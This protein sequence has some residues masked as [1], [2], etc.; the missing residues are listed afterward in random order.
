MFVFQ[1]VGLEV[2]DGVEDLFSQTVVNNRRDC[3]L[4]HVVAILMEDE[5]PNNQVNSSPK[6][7][8]N[9]LVFGSKANLN[10]IARELKLAQT[11]KVDGDLLEDEVVAPL[12][13]QFEHILDQIVPEFVLDE[14][15]NICDNLIRN[16]HFLLP[17]AFFE[18]SLH[19]A[20]PVFVSANLDAVVHACFNDEIRVQGFG[21]IVRCMIIFVGQ[22]RG[23]EFHQNAL[24]HMVAVDVIDQPD[25]IWLQHSDHHLEGL[26]PLCELFNDG[27]HDSGA[28]DIAR[29][30]CG[31]IANLF[32]KHL[33]F[34]WARSLDDF[35]TEVVSELVYHGVFKDWKDRFDESWVKEI[36]PIFTLRDLLLNQSA[37]HL[38]E[39]VES[40]VVDDLL[41]VEWKLREAFLLLFFAQN[42]IN[43]SFSDLVNLLKFRK[44][45][46]TG[47]IFGG[48]LE[49]AII[50]ISSA[51]INL[52]IVP[53]RVELI[54]WRSG[55][56]AVRK[57]VLPLNM[58][59]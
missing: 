1:Q 48:L 53:N 52:V 16:S 55:A 8:V 41:L 49:F 28:V 15:V 30:R 21:E 32:D 25:S 47:L 24:E 14:V 40:D 26:G 59:F 34:S 44:V 19:H 38:I 22:I 3:A 13:L 57:V 56:E 39:A 50:S 4:E 33:Q 12:I 27:L 18:A 54:N 46:I 29:D 42:P 31:V 11:H 23:F 37:A 51:Q 10:D 20:A 2:F 9:R 45:R 36:M 17:R 58:N 5:L 43:H 35:L 6:N 7:L